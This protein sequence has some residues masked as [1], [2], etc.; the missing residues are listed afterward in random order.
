M[1]LTAAKEKKHLRYLKRL[2]KSAF[3]RYERKPFWLIRRKV[4]QGEMDLWVVEEAGKPVGMASVM[5]AEALVLIDYFAIDDGRRG[6]GL[7][8]RALSLLKEQYG[9]KGILLE[10]ETLDE[11]AKNLEQRVSR[12]R[13][14]LRNG[15]EETG[16]RLSVF[17]NRLELLCWNCQE[18]VSFDAYKE[19]YQ[20]ALGK[21]LAERVVLL[22]K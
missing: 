2:Y 17:G 10:I 14:Y 20:R 13:F 21:R 6:G 4:K 12:K 15:M 18:G 9:D 16:L 11:T 22:D 8:S 7:G 1:K 5:L 3:P 19:I